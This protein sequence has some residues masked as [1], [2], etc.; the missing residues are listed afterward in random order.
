M[1]ATRPGPKGVAPV[2]GSPLGGGR[3]ADQPADDFDAIDEDEEEDDE[4]L[5]GALSPPH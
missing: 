2:P 1:L 5:A 3:D 4:E